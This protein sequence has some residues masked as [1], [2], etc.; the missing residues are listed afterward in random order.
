MF[1]PRVITITRRMLSIAGMAASVALALIVANCGATTSES[2][3][4]GSPS[5]A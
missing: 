3:A 4:R 1:A 2:L 5:A